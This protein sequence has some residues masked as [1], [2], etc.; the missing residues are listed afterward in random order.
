MT[1]I[2]IDHGSPLGDDTVIARGHRNPDGT[3]IIESMEVRNCA[4]ERIV[5]ELRVR[6]GTQAELRERTDLRLATVCDWLGVLLSRHEVHIHAWEVQPRGGHPIAVYAN[7]P[8]ANM[9]RPEP[10]INA[11]RSKR[12]RTRRLQ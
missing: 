9:P 8:G 3:L 5:A 12:S 7:G 6:P 11:Q 10:S 4:R 2:G 1:I